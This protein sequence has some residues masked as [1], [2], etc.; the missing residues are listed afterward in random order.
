MKKVTNGFQTLPLLKFRSQLAVIVTAMTGNAHF[1][2]LQTQ[3]SALTTAADNYYVLDTKAETRDKNA[4]IAR[5]IA[6]IEVTTMLH[7]L[8]FGVTAVSLGNEEILSSSGFPFTQPPQKTV[9]LRKPTPPKLSTGANNGVINVRVQRQ[10]GTLAY[11]YYIAPAA[12]G[13]K[14]VSADATWHVISHNAGKYD[15]EDLVS[16]QPYLIKVG[17]VGVR[18]QEVI[19]D[20]IA[21]TPQ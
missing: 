5:N 10:K 16:S 12:A 17:L 7:K 6:R 8:G 9:P 3:V 13:G 14:T 20:A 21:Y 1:P 15:F 18:G 4:V 19:S 11:N 2:T